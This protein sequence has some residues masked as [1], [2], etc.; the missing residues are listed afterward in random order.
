MGALER[1]E[2]STLTYDIAS[3]TVT[4]TRP[5]VYIVSGWA[6]LTPN[7]RFG[8]GFQPA[9]SSDWNVPVFTT[10]NATD[11]GVAD[12]LP[13]WCDNGTKI[14]VIRGGAGNFGLTRLIVSSR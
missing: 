6:N 9:G 11:N 1:V 8:P 2:G 13:Y 4:V 14:A 3:G 10:G 7:A 12:S 5:G